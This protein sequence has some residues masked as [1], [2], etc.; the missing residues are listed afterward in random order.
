MLLRK[1]FEDLSQAMIK[2]NINTRKEPLASLIQ[3]KK[4]KKKED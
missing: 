1:I 2:I 3:K 4:K